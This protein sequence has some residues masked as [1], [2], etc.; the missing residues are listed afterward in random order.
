M[1]D[2]FNL[3]KMNCITCPLNCEIKPKTSLRVSFC[4]N[5]CFGTWPEGSGYFSIGIVE[6]VL[7]Q[8]HNYFY[9]GCVF[10]DFSIS[11]LRLLMDRQWI[12]YLLETRLNIIVVCDKHLQPLANYWLKNESGIFLI[13]YPND[14]MPYVTEKIKNKF[15]G[16]G[17]VPVK[18]ETLSKLELNV[19]RELMAGRDCTSVAALFNIDIRSVY[20]AKQRVEK[21]MGNDVND[22]FRFSL[23]I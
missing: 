3:Q 5:F 19:L 8:S 14:S 2:R 21:K 23:A 16:R 13:I 20:A 12:D 17:A 15:I 18:G 10:V 6:G 7:K 11:F 9:N 1:P 4:Q 22:L